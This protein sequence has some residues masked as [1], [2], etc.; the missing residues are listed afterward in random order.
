MTNGHIK[1]TIAF[2]ICALFTCLAFATEG[3]AQRKADSHNMYIRQIMD[4][5]YEGSGFYFGCASKVQYLTTAK[6]KAE[7]FFREFSYNTPEN[8]FKQS[9]IYHYPGAK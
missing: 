3:A 7:R 1:R 8:D 5:Y 4:T 9:K 2:P 6:D